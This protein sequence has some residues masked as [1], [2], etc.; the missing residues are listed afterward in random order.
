MTTTTAREPVAPGAPVEGTPQGYRSVADGEL[1]QP[2][3]LSEYFQSINTVLRLPSKARRA[4]AKAE[5]EKAKA[6]G[7]SLPSSPNVRLP[8]PMLVGAFFLVVGVF[9]IRPIMAAVTSP[10]THLP[11]ESYG[12]WGTNEGKYAGHMFE[13]SATSIAFRTSVKSPDYTWH[14]IDHI[15][16]TVTPDST[17]YTVQYLEQGKTADFSFWHIPGA[18][19]GAPAIRFAHAT[20]V[21]W[22]KTPYLPIAKPQY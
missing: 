3:T 2:W 10:E 16:A 22:T 19:A 13:V 17:L 21:T 9:V 6:A 14:R 5:Q 11:S 20:E 12:V 7:L 15:K 1:H 4:A 18:G 8:V